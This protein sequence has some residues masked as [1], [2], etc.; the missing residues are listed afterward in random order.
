M[1]ESGRSKFCGGAGGFAV[2][3]GRRAV[4]RLAA[5]LAQGTELAYEAVYRSQPAVKVQ[6]GGT[7]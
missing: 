5:S 6:A 1:V 2:R 7:R 3:A 4:I